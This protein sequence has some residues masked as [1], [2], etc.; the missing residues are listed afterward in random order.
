MKANVT[1]LSAKIALIILLP[2]Q[3]RSQEPPRLSLD[4]SATGP[5]LTW[6]AT[7]Q[8]PDGSIE[9]P[10]FEL[11]RSI[12]LHHWQPI[13]QRQRAVAATPGQSLGARLEP[14]GSLAFYRLL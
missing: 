13:N 6:P 8:K 9:R 10:Y 14:D 11:Q 2:L 3:I 7:V 1:R 12:D 5:S 4:R